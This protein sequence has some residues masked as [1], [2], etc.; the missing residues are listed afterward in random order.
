MT[1]EISQLIES[2]SVERM[3]LGDRRSMN[4]IKMTD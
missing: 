4:L 1:S 3:P 2:R